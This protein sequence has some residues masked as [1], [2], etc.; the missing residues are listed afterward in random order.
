MI[1]LHA[2]NLLLDEVITGTIFVYDRMTT[3]LFDLDF[4]YS[5]VSVQFVLIFDVICDMF[6]ALIHVYTPIEETV[7][8]TH[9][10][11]YL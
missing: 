7:I 8:V 2:M 11:F 10:Y 9:V 1:K 5:Y 6:D 4:T 3:V